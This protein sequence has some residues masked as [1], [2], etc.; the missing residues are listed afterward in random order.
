M[1]GLV[2][3]LFAAA[4]LGV[5]LGACNDVADCPSPSSIHPNG[6]CSGDHLECPYDLVTPGAEATETSCTCV[7]GSW[8]CPTPPEDDAAGASDDGSAQAE[9][10]TGPDSDTASA[11]AGSDG[12]TDAGGP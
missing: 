7:S 9:G 12:Q 4:V 8:S 5:A 10:E 1:F 3:A 11:D 6:S 2:P